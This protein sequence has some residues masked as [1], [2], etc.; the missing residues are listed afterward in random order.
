MGRD[1]A[2]RMRYQGA[3]LEAAA[4]IVLERVGELGGTGGLI[5]V[6]AEGN[7]TL[8]FI[9]EGMYRGCVHPG[10]EPQVAIYGD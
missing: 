3:S 9:S 6:D 5:A 4:R 8:P 10:E 2:A 7:V 1:V